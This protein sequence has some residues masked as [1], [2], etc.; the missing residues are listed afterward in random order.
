MGDSPH[1][2]KEKYTKFQKLWIGPCKI[3]IILG[4]NSY[5][6]KYEN[7]WVLSYIVNGFH[8]K[9]STDP[10]MVIREILR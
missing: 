4:N 7:D 3:A 10:T 6:M 1:A 8:R 5:I 9:H 2:D